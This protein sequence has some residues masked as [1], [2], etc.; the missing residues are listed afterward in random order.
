MKHTR[1]ILTEETVTVPSE[2][3]MNPNNRLYSVHKMPKFLML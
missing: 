3:D 2:N 1:L